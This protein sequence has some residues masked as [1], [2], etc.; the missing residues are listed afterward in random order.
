MVADIDGDVATRVLVDAVQTARDAMDNGIDATEISGF[1]T[2]FVAAQN[3][4]TLL[5][6][7]SLVKDQYQ[8]KID[9]LKAEVLALSDFATFMVPGNFDVT[10][11][12]ASTIDLVIDGAAPV[13]DFSVMMPG[14][15]TVDRY[16]IADNG[17]VNGDTITVT[18]ATGTVAVTGDTSAGGADGTFTITITDN[19]WDV[20][21]TVTVDVTDDTN[22]SETFT[23][24]A[25]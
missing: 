15:T 17:P 12:T 18:A 10:A 2:A 6:A 16:T 4:I 23:I 25:D 9:E 1:E 22:G 21:D 24:N 20:S 5:P 8:A 3:S 11:D 7:E 14:S 13:T 19:F